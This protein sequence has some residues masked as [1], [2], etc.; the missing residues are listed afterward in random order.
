MAR[1][2]VVPVRGM[3][4]GGCAATIERGLKSMPGA[5]SAAVSF[6]TRTATVSGDVDEPA[7]LA[8]IGALGYQGVSSAEAEAAAGRAGGGA[9][10]DDERAPARRRAWIAGGLSLGSLLAATSS[11]WLS[12]ACALAAL[13]WPGGPIFAQALRL[14][15]ARH[16]AMDS[17]VALGSAAAFA[18][19]TWQQL[20]ADGVLAAGAAGSA[21]SVSGHAAGAHAGAL[22]VAG[23]AHDHPLFAMAALIVTFVLIGRALEE[24]ARAAAA[25]SL[26]AL[27][28]RAPHEARLV[29]DGVER[30]VPAAAVQVGDVLRVGAGEAVPADGVVL[31]GRSGFDESLLTGESLPQFRVPGDALVAGSTNVGGALVSLRATAV[32]SEATLARLLAL[33]REAQGSKPPVQR[34]ADRVA[35]V[36]VPVVLAIAAG[37]F[38]FGA[39]DAGA[40]ALAAVAVIVVACPCALGLATPT[41]VQVATGRAAQ[42]GILVRDAGALESCARLDTLLVDKT[43]TLTMGEPLV[44]GL[45][46]L[47]AAAPDGGHVIERT[48]HTWAALVGAGV[49][50]EGPRAASGAQA[51]VAAPGA[52]APRAT[53]AEVLKEAELVAEALA[54]AA[55]V[56][57][58]SGHPLATAIR[59]E[60]QR[61]GLTIPAVLMAD[62]HS[63]GGGVAGRLAGAAGAAGAGGASSASGANGASGTVGAGG[64]NG[65]SDTGGA[66]VLVGSPEFVA[67]RGVDVAT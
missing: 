35:A 59:S 64:A 9:A 1:T 55:A 18:L 29:S 50:P 7:V 24:N 42:L 10:A 45:A 52:H 15:A 63:G 61:L 16:A 22:T 12:A 26:V 60:A 57:I 4:C 47:D 36:F 40:R 48:S 44:E 28:A 56:E 17:L 33:V 11:P 14:L 51:A 20:V 19:A 46:L 27:G 39:G 8:T 21:G 13:A 30:R 53:E 58:A 66:E 38:L 6:A 3:T 34:L 41:A 54:A 25:A 49:R 65:A 5:R 37:V 32:G 23:A 67:G 43:G 2:I 62:L 31:Q